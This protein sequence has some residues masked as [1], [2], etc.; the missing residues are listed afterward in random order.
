MRMREHQLRVHREAVEGVNACACA[1]TSFEYIAKRSKVSAK[2]SA[3]A[4]SAANHQSM[5]IELAQNACA[6]EPTAALWHLTPS[7]PGGAL[8]LVHSAPPLMCSSH[9]SRAASRRP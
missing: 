1:R 5:L 8:Y 3:N 6:R 2:P 4:A 9:F 7:T